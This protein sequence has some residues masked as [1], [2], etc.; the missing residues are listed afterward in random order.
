[1]GEKFMSMDKLTQ[2]TLEKCSSTR[3][4]GVGTFTQKLLPVKSTRL[5]ITCIFCP[6]VD[7]NSAVFIIIE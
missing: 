4:T 7:N 6:S 3:V 5:N 1:M 2:P